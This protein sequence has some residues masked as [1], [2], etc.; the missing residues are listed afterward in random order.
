MLRVVNL[1]KVFSVFIFLGTLSLVYAFMPIMVKLD[2]EGTLEI[3][4]ENFF[5]GSI[6][7]FVMVNVLTLV[8]QNIL[9][10][11]LSSEM[12]KSWIG[13]FTFVINLYLSFLIGFLGV[14]NNPADIPAANYF[15]L[16]W[17]GPILFL[18]WIFGLIFLVL[19]KD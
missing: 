12:L 5:Y 15:Y 2:E 10:E 11:K 6:A 4:K 1:V 17:L 8:I 9:N 13:G 18:F 16:N 3:Q 7:V 19:K 14:L